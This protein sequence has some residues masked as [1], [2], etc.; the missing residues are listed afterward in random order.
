MIFPKIRY[1][2]ILIL[3]NFTTGNATLQVIYPSL[4]NIKKLPTFAQKLALTSDYFARSKVNKDGGEYDNP[5]VSNFPVKFNALGTD[6]KNI[7]LT[8]AY[9][10]DVN[11][12]PA[13]TDAGCRYTQCY[14]HNGVQ[15]ITPATCPS[16]VKRF[17][18]TAA[19]FGRVGGFQN[20]FQGMARGPEHLGL[21]NYVFVT[22]NNWHEDPGFGPQ[23][24]LFI[25]KM[26]QQK[27]GPFTT[28]PGRTNY[29]KTVRNMTADFPNL[30]HPGGAQMCGKY[31]TTALQIPD[32]V[33]KIVFYQFKVDASDNLQIDPIKETYIQASAMASALTRLANGHFLAAGSS[34]KLSFFYSRS[35]ILE[36][37]FDLVGAIDAKGYQAINFINDADGSL[38]LVGT[39]ND[40]PQAPYYYKTIVHTENHRG[41][42]IADLYK[43][44]IPANISKI[45][46]PSS[47]GGWTLTKI[48]SKRFPQLGGYN[49]AAA[50][51]VYVAN[52]ENLYMYS[53]PHWLVFDAVADP[54]LVLP[55]NGY[56]PPER[57]MLPPDPEFIKQGRQ[58][59]HNVYLQ[60]T[61]FR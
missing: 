56:Y 45:T 15:V 24:H 25:I 30:I 43:I 10:Y 9:K 60:I 35:C 52:Q 12:K 38:Y 59:Q 26:G 11:D 16:A 29:I 6:N 20:H 1:F 41:T 13:F 53:S 33:E 36:D 3:L 54:D 2:L 31:F 58:A 8:A 7:F 34:S 14:P 57:A 18:A 50:T 55:H 17:F 32:P 28:Q 37:G 22:G 44:G 23:A 27:A 48:Q 46:D 61:Q 40:D 4:E 39:Y 47:S 51:G 19:G 21:G 5:W 49:F 42:D